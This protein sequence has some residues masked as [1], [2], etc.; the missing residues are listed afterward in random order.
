MPEWVLFEEE[1]EYQGKIWQVGHTARYVKVAVQSEENLS[2]QL[3][4]VK[5][6]TLSE[7]ELMLGSVI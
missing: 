3:R 5:D 7:G 2:N 6:L 4:P 1:M